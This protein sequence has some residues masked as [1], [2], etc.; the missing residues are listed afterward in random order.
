M[1]STAHKPAYVGRFAPSPTGDLHFGS[2]IAATASYLQ[3][4][5]ARGQWLIRMEDI[6]PPREVPGS[7][8][9]ILRDLAQLGLH[10]DCA[11]LFQ[12]TRTRAY[13]SAVDTL[14]AEG[15]AF[16]CACSRKDLP[17]SGVYP[18]TCRNGLPPGKSPRTVRLNVSG[19]T[20][21]FTDLIQGRI[22]E[23]LEHSTGDF[24]IRRADGLPAYQL[25]VVIDDHFQGV[26]EIVRGADLLDSTARQIHLQRCL[27]LKT[28][29][30]AHL[31]LVT[32]AD[33]EKLGKR[34]GSDPVGRLPAAA[35]IRLALQFLGQNPPDGMELEELWSWAKEH[36]QI[37]SIPPSRKPA[38]LPA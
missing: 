29:D 6:D 27:G 3:S 38:R 23:G 25:A 33:G 1:E 34:F 5:Y 9:G 28:P 24:V 37:K 32:G 11:V 7:A 30:Y 36:W 20:I 22:E 16:W 15:K 4:K 10:S 31:P 35:A 13:E 26:T 12:S 2:L 17:V 21:G 8:T 18:G 19:A 14:L